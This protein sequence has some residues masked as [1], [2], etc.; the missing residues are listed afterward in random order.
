MREDLQTALAAAIEHLSNA[1]QDRRSAMHVPVI[2]TADGDLRMMVLRACAP[3][4]ALLRFHTDAR[5]PKVAAITEQPQVSILAHDPEA[6]VQLRLRGHARVEL[7]G[8][9]AD[10][11]WDEAS[12]YARR[13]Y[14]AQAAPG[15]NLLGPASGLPAE[16]EGQVPSAEQLLPARQNFAVMLVE[17]T[18]L[19]WLHLAH[20]GH[21]RAQFSRRAVG[22]AWRGEWVGP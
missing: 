19:D 20:T 2:G 5:S 21:R 1:A 10:A 9:T 11:A 14:L 6:R 12:A 3:D 8:V 17:P 18:S 7:T 13:C 4:L 16:V 15:S 22:D